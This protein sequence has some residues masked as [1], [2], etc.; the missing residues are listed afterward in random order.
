MKKISSPIAD[1]LA[2]KFR[3]D[4]DISLTEAIN[5]KSLLRKLNI[6]TVFRP[7]SGNFCGM[8]L[9][10]PAKL[11]FILINSN[12]PK[13]RQHFTIAHELYHLFIDNN[14]T[15]HIC[16]NL[17][18]EK[19][20]SELN[21]NMFAASLLMPE[22]GLRELISQEEI[23]EK[24]IRLG[25]IIRMEQYFSV[26]RKALL[27][28]LKNC[29]MISPTEFDLLSNYSVV[30]TAKQYG[31]NTA[32]Y[33]P[34]NEDLV[35]GDFGEKARLLYEKEIISEGHYLELLNMISDGKN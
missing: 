35:I 29:K 27:I 33:M 14:P 28:R 34:G 24:S 7:L 5:L 12:D 21:A 30:E 25:T 18:D 20:I 8:S 19:D 15:P 3:A 10:S 11:K 13:G 6:L 32:L 26:S 23:F 2:K 9:I 4:N 31:Y 16:Q 22:E 1:S 17:F